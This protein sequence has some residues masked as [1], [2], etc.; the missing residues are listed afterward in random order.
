[1]L[2]LQDKFVD[3]FSS[4]KTDRNKL[5]PSQYAEKYRYLSSEVSTITGKFKYNLTPYL[6]ETVD[7]FSPFHPAKVVAVMK[8]GQVGFTEG[9]IINGILWMIAN[10]PGN[11]LFLSADDGLSQEAVEMRLDQGIQ[12]CGIQ[13]L[14]G[15]NVIRK[16]NQRTG[17][18][19]KYKEYVGGRLFAG[20]LK[21][22]NKISAQ[23]SIK[24]ALIDDW[25]KA[26]QADKKEGSKFEL[27]QMRLSSAAKSMKQYYIS[28]PGTKPSNIEAVY[29]MGD[30]RQWVVPCPD[31]GVFIKLIWNQ[32]KDK[33]VVGV[34]FEKDSKGGLIESSIGYVCQECGEF[35]K[36]KHKYEMNL[37]GYWKSTAKE[38][39]EGYYS[40]HINNFNSAPHMYSWTDYVY[41]WLRIWD[42]GSESISKRKVFR[43][44]V[45]G[46]PWEE[47]KQGV[48]KNILIK[49]TRKYSVGTIPNKQS[50]DDG[51]GIIVLITCATDLNGTIDDP[52]LD[53]EV[54]AWAENGSS[55]R[56]DQG[57]I[58]TYGLRA[59]DDK[60]SDWTYR[61]EQ[62]NNV[63]NHLYNE[64]INKKYKTDEGKE[65]PIMISGIDTG[66][67][68]FYA[69]NFIDTDSAKLTGLKGGSDDKYVNINK[70]LAFYKAS[71]K[72]KN[73][74]ILN[75]HHL[76][77]ILSEMIHAKWTKGEVQPAGFM[78]FPVP[79]SEKFR[80]YYFSQ[81]ESEHKIL[82][83]NE[84]GEATSW[85][86]QKKTTT[87]QNHFFDTAVY[88]L[89]LREIFSQNLCKEAGIKDANWFDYVELI[90]K[91]AGLS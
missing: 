41:K 65:M 64:V 48:K 37:S 80:P 57:S 83:E 77:D 50:K 54:V 23:R 42:N 68:E 5:T 89:A 55:Y 4:I 44:Q 88:N 71:K 19:S 28:T 52:R 1:M 47:R 43:N 61:N 32:L 51:N 86:W 21:S 2:E 56:I 85:K 24:Y 38:V 72:R 73:L 12:S 81:F 67:L 53:Y 66:Y 27:I 25:D 87:A 39:R 82:E 62:P 69:F 70:D 33:E 78:N 40:Y 90:K 20:G 9:V 49:N 7:C 31:C 60:L 46:L 10:N 59:K 58:G 11:C 35:F 76:K 30:Q 84:D 34:Y 36:E 26:E 8:G 74:Y 75:T 91:I 29:L 13:D 79:T 45:E 3:L 16:R 14:I 6:R 15:P 22:I 63:W 17:D 18:T